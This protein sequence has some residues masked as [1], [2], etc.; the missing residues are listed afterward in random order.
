MVGCVGNFNGMVGF[1]LSMVGTA[2]FSS[3]LSCYSSC[4]SSLLVPLLMVLGSWLLVTI[5]RE[6]SYLSTI[7]TFSFSFASFLLMWW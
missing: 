5:A 4:I 7:V 1:F 6:V 2:R 3:S